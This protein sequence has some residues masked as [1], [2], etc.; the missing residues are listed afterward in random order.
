MLL[1]LNSTSAMIFN[2]ILGL[3]KRFERLYNEEESKKTVISKAAPPP[4]TTTSTRNTIKTSG[5]QRATTEEDWKRMRDDESFDTI[6]DGKA[7]TAAEMKKA[8][9]V[10]KIFH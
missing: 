7:K 1:V 6:F 5:M 4:T 9:K 8:I 2:R 3:P 10:S